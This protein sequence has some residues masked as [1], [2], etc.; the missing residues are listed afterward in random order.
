MLTADTTA[1][2]NIVDPVTLENALNSGQMSR[3]E[4]VE[5]FINEADTAFITMLTKHC[6]E[7][8]T[9]DKGMLAQH[10]YPQ[11]LAAQI[12]ESGAGPRLMEPVAEY[13]P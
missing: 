11:I 4:R 5:L 3:D 10:F 7:D 13:L 6:M 1:Y 8:M 9:K 2:H 12:V